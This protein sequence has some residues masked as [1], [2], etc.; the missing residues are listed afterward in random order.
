M[1]WILSLLPVRQLGAWC[2]TA[3][4]G[5]RK[6]ARLRQYLQSLRREHWGNRQRDSNLEAGAGLDRNSPT[7][8]V[9]WISEVSLIR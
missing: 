7:L 1:Y 6:A 4:M 2:R 3:R 9:L 8:W 5:M